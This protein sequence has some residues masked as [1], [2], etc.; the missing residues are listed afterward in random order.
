MGKLVVHDA[1][2]RAG[3]HDLTDHVKLRAG[4]DERMKTL[5]EYHSLSN[6]ILHVPQPPR[7]EGCDR[8]NRQT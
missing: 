1:R 7:G 4:N 2:G 3:S 6:P 8:W 5:T